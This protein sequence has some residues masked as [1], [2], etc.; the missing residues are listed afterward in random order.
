MTKKNIVVKDGKKVTVVESI[1]NLGKEAGAL[2]KDIL[3]E[4][5]KSK[6]RLL[7]LTKKFQV[8]VPLDSAVT[9]FVELSEIYIKSVSLVNNA[10]KK[11]GRKKSDFRY[12]LAIEV[13]LEYLSEHYKGALPKPIRYPSGGYIFDATNR[14]INAFNAKNN[15]KHPL[16]SPRTADYWLKE[17]RAM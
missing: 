5:I 16:I 8:Q 3:S 1:E 9:E 14:K 15:T 4:L 6:N 2:Q 13:M 12:S 10:R 11:G 7:K 17:F